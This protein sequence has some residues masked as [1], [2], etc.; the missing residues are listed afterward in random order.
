[1][2]QSH[3]MA[4]IKQYRGKTWRAIVRRKGFPVESKTFALKK[5]AEAW[6]ASVEARM[7]VSKFDELQ[8]KQSRTTTVESLFTKYIEEVAPGMKGRNELGTLKRIKR[9]AKF[10]PMLLD[11]LRS[12]DIRDWRDNRVKKVKPASVHREL[13]TISAV[14]THAMKE[15]GAPLEANPCHAVSRFKNADK[16]REKRWSQEDIDAFL[17]AADWAADKL[18]KVGRDYVGWALL[19][20]LETAMREGEICLPTVADFNEAERYLHLVDT[21]NGDSRNVPLSK[22]AIG[23]LKILCEG[24]KP[25]DKIVPLVAN[26]LCEYVL[27]VRKKCG[28][29]HLHFHDTRHTAATAMSKKLSNVLEL[30]AQTGHRSLKSLQR[31]Y[32]PEAADIASKLD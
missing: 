8:L 28:L 32:H 30:S 31:Y 9:D 18:P 16:R 15:W 14:F 12:D 22:K 24:K 20:A 21:K 13:N 3:P 5:D 4:S 1:V 6:A 10:M 26:T 27:D 23:Y 17:K 29:Q 2:L 25:E 11:R 7:G 19:L